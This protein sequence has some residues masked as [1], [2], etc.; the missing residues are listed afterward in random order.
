VIVKVKVVA[1]KETEAVQCF[2]KG[3]QI[4]E[5]TLPEEILKVVK[6]KVIMVPEKDK[7]TNSILKIRIEDQFKSLEP[8]LRRVTKVSWQSMGGYKREDV[9][10]DRLL[11]GFK[12]FGFV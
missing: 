7:T 4:P 11:E 5:T 2:K 3:T 12:G 10:V 9:E 8:L 1:I 6:Q